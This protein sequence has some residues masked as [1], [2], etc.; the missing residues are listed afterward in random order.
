MPNYW[1]D[2]IHLT[3]PDALKTAQ[4]YEGMFNAKR[5]STREAADGHTTNVELDLKGSRVLIAERTGEPA[6]ALSPSGV[7]HGLEHFGIT[8]DN[9]EAAVAELKAKG[10][11]FRDEIRLAPTGAK[12]AFLW[13]PE[14]VLIELVERKI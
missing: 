2:H 10:V 7:F 12:I 11:K 1:F 9:I 6:Q 14:N 13:G 3:C 4:F 5:V 8:I